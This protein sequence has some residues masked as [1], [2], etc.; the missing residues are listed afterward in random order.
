[1]CHQDLYLG[2]KDPVVVTIEWQ[3]H[4]FING[5]QNKNTLQKTVRDVAMVTKF[6]KLKNETR[7]LHK[8]EPT[9][10]DTISSWGVV[11][12]AVS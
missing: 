2:Q 6:L 9:E 8:I 7:E 11:S 3:I 4:E 1:M 10:L 12:V 5:Q